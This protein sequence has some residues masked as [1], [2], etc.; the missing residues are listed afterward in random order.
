MTAFG[1]GFNNLGTSLRPSI[2]G[3]FV[4]G[5]QEISPNEIPGDGTLCLFPKGDYTC[6]YARQF[7]QNG[8]IEVTFVPE[9]RELPQQQVAAPQVTNIDLT[10][11]TDRLDKIEK[12]LNRKP[13]YY[14]KPRKSNGGN[15]NE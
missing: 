10:E 14:N 5:P 13:H 11:I 3:R 12:T 7:G 9:N 2:P 6:I 4:S 8:I 15:K 1:N